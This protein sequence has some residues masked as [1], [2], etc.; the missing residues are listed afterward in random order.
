LHKAG[1]VMSFLFGGRGEVPVQQSPDGTAFV[2]LRLA[3][4]QFVVLK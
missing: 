3:P 4:Q 2:T 1:D